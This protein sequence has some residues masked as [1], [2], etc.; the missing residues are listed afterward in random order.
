M[1]HLDVVVD[2]MVLKPGDDFVS[3]ADRWFFQNPNGFFLV[4]D[5]SVFLAASQGHFHSEACEVLFKILKLCVDPFIAPFL[6]IIHIVQFLQ[7]HMEGFI[8]GID[9][10]G[11]HIVYLFV[12]HPEVRVDEKESLQRE[13][14]KLQ[15]PGA[16][17]DGDV[18][19]VV[20]AMFLKPKI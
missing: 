1:H 13:I 15:I 2:G 6:S 17:I 5:F 16:M 3:K 9:V 19:D 11:L 7:N 10:H 18:S 12:F 20:N 4:D 14:F 8:Q